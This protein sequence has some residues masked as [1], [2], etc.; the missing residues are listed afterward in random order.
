[1]DSLNHPSPIVLVAAL[2]VHVIALIGVDVE[3]AVNH[4]LLVVEGSILNHVAM[5]IDKHVVSPNSRARVQR[6]VE[7]LGVEVRVDVDPIDAAD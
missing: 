6:R 1:M 7:I 2:K 3:D 5:S 4:V